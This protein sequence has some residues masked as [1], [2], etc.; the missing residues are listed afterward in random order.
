MWSKL[1][2]ASKLPKF[3][4]VR[5]EEEVRRVCVVRGKEGK[6]DEGTA[7]SCMRGV[8]GGTA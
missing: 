4:D 7:G 3:R 2:G 1:E 8:S 5:G 6:D